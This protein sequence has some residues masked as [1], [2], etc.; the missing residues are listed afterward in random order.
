MIIERLSFKVKARRR[1]V[2]A[3]LVPGLSVAAI[4]DPA[5]GRAFMSVLNWTGRCDGTSWAEM[6]LVDGNGTRVLLALEQGPDGRS[7]AR[8]VNERTG[9]EMEAPRQVSLAL[10]LPANDDYGDCSLPLASMV[11]A[12][13]AELCAAIAAM[14][15]AVSDADEIRAKR[16]ARC[17]RLEA[18]S[19]RVHR[20]RARRVAL[21]SRLSWIAERIRFIDG[22]LACIESSLVACDQR[23]EIQDYIGR[24]RACL[25]ECDRTL[26][27]AG[28]AREVCL[29]A[30]AERAA[31]PGNDGAFE[32]AVAAEVRSLERYQRELERKAGECD[33]RLSRATAWL[34]RLRAEQA[35]VHGAIG[36]LGDE[37]F[38]EETASHA[39]SVS[40]AI[41]DK[42]KALQA[43]GEQIASAD[44]VLARRKL[45]QR[46]TIGGV[47]LAGLSLAA[48]MLPPVAEKGASIFLVMLVAGLLGTAL[49]IRLGIEIEERAG[50][51]AAL[52]RNRAAL[53]RQ[54]VW[55]RQRLSALLG[56]CTLEDY[57]A[58]LNERRQLAQR[59]DAIADEMKDALDDLTRLHNA[60]DF[61]RV[62]AARVKERLTDI[63]R[64][65]GFDSAAS[66]L[67]AH[68]RYLRLDSA[69]E[70]ARRKLESSLGGRTESA[71]ARDMELAAEEIAVAEACRDALSHPR[72]DG[73][74]G[75]LSDEYALKAEESKRLAGEL[76]SGRKELEEVERELSAI[77]VWEAAS[78]AAEAA[79]EEETT[80]QRRGCAALARSLLQGLLDARAPEAVQKLGESASEILR[81]I[82]EDRDAAFTCSL[83]N[84]RVVFA[85]RDAQRADERMQ[86]AARLAIE[87]AQ[88]EP[89]DGSDV[90][91]LVVQRWGPTANPAELLSALRRVA[92]TRQVILIAS[93]DVLTECAP[94]D[95][96]ITV[97]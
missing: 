69:F 56:G 46:L 94:G 43:I 4:G 70:D 62:S 13:E 18:E 29:T 9:E 23:D 71:I 64:T 24:L 45:A 81:F 85:F 89:A 82:T 5:L 68:E 16:H 30:E 84:G 26:S 55:N 75:E 41:S 96:T 6:A 8:A 77:D 87:L 93:P 14:D 17:A 48:V 73:R 47:T 33:A 61:T 27:S 50:S 31:C 58:A 2:E 37:R 59:R 88:R 57:V 97:G 22:R 95:H 78:D 54:L 65:A 79:M 1:A 72:A 38:S 80:A 19:S 39:R 91:P 63:L 10:T 49:G 76:A 32:P 11:C 40:I 90:A 20:L 74:L 42:E 60:A 28:E 15:E 83:E 35:L 66:Y 3:R 52:D 21:E 51:R 86:L 92:L 25:A 53:T 44:E 12:A 67:D 36:S 7:V 34:G